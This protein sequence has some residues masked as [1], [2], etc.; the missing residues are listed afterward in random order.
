M[1]I[2]LSNSPFAI[3]LSMSGIERKCIYLFMVTEKK[4]RFQF[5]IP[6]HKNVLYTDETEYWKMLFSLAPEIAQA[7]ENSTTPYYNTVE[8]TVTEIPLNR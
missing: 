4:L 8:F 7:S 6:L 5:G 3:R 1:S 2:S